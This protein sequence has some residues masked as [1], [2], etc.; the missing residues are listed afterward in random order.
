M[1][2]NIDEIKNELNDIMK[3]FNS[4][5]CP[6]CG[7]IHQC[8][9]HLCMDGNITIS[10]KAGIIPPCHKYTSAIHNAVDEIIKKY[11]LPRRY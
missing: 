1:N 8:R 11:K 4:E 2:Q 3:R 7:G 5:E 9:L 10:T 6:E